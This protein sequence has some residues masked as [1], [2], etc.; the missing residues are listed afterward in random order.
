MDKDG[1]M[2]EW[3]KSWRLDK[4]EDGEGR[5]LIVCANVRYRPLIFSK[6]CHYYFSILI[7]FLFVYQ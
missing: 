4:C 7:S 2:D 5:W 6:S 1:K 3:W